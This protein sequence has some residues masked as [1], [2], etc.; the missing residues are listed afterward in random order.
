MEKIQSAFSQVDITPDYQVELVGCDRNDRRSLGVLHH[1]YAQI[2]LFQSE[3][4]FYCLIT[5]DSLGLTTELSN[6]LRAQVAK[7]FN[8]TVS[9]IML[10][11]SHTHSA[12]EPTPYALNG[13]KYC[14]YMFKQVLQGAINAK[15]FLKPCK[16]GWALTK[17]DIGENRRDGC[18][19]VDD[20]LGALKIVDTQNGSTIAIALRVTAHANVL[21]R[22]NNFISS[23]YFGVAR[24]VLS[25]D[26][27]CPIMMIQGAA[28]NIKPIGVHK[29]YGGSVS[30]LD[31]VVDRLRRSASKLSFEIE[32]ITDI[33]MVSKSIE[34]VSYI[35]TKAEAEKIA[36]NSGMDA[37]NWLLECERLR[38]AD[39]EEQR[40]KGEFQLLKIN[41]GCLCG[42]P[43][44]IFCELA[45]N[46]TKSSNNQLLFLNGYTNGCTGYLP[47]KVEWEKGG[48]ETLYS[49]LSYYQ[50]HG[51]VMP[52]Y[53]NTEEQIVELVENTWME[54]SRHQ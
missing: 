31:I 37:S 9:H 7:E 40:Q 43:E 5:I 28:G 46:A 52:F 29:I 35:P 17:T 14:A 13:E 39:I 16:I 53:A 34:Y 25:N 22:E 24:N 50:F 15:K 47:T 18:T 21:M 32:D 2:L 11:F 20:R 23:D 41:A 1:L 19:A 33:Q 27:S 12:P 51:H 36:T 4:D 8:T 30:D 45:I 10:N 3:D 48:Y 38:K 6:A 44:E 54:L 49:Y 26:F 42:V